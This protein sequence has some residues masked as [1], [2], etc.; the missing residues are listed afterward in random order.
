MLFTYSLLWMWTESPH[1]LY[2]IRRKST[3]HFSY[4]PA[5]LGKSLL[6][7]LSRRSGQTYPLVADQADLRPLFNLCSAGSSYASKPACLGKSLNTMDF[8]DI[9]ET[10]AAW[11]CSTRLTSFIL[12]AC[13]CFSLVLHAWQGMSPKLIFRA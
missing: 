3:S 5:R 11:S 9:P 10:L 2:S 7:G 4:K 12:L 6:L 8:P 1:I 13:Y